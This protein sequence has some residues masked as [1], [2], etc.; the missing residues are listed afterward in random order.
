M[1][2]KDELLREKAADR[3]TLRRLTTEGSERANECEGL[4]RTIEA[5][6][7]ELA[8]G[9]RREIVAQRKIEETE[10]AIKRLEAERDGLLRVTCCCS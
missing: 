6:R 7:A 3:D 10:K 8:D 4:R 5:Q 1:N 2:E 9:E